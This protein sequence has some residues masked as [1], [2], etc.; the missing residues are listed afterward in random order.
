MQYLGY[1][2]GLTF[3]Q[4]Y[5]KTNVEL[6]IVATCLE[7]MSSKYF[8]Y[9]NYPNME[10]SIAIE[11]SAA[12]PYH[13][14]PVS[15]EGRKY[16]DGGILNNFPLDYYDEK[17]KGHESNKYMETVGILLKNR[18]LKIENNFERTYISNSIDEFLTTLIMGCSIQAS[19]SHYL[20]ELKYGPVDEKRVIIVDTLFIEDA[21]FEIDTN[22]QD[23]LVQNG[24]LSA[25]KFFV[26][27]KTILEQNIQ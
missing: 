3:L 27:G 19:F 17:V 4:H 21:A 5:E 13:F 9:K 18:N 25:Y 14:E 23:L 2:P 20:N 16:I 7:T 22:T 6:T 15:F 12:V 24:Y 10:I 11:M 26:E 8:N 1:N